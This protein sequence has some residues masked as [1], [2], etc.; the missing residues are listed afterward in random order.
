MASKKKGDHVLVMTPGPGGHFQSEPGTEPGEQLA[1]IVG[2]DLM[3]DM[4]DKDGNLPEAIKVTMV[5]TKAPEPDT[6]EEPE[7]EPA[8]A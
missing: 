6:E 8:T 5:P 3:A 1:M 2:G 7:P 4:A